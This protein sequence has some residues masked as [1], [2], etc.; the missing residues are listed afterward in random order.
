M[1]LINYM[2][3]LVQSM[4]QQLKRTCKVCKSSFAPEEN[5]DTSC[6]FHRG[7]WIG[8]ENSKHL[9]KR[10]GS[11]ENIGISFFW[12]CCDEGI[13][14]LLFSYFLKHLLAFIDN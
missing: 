6:R 1:Q 7:R 11:K 5:F 9:G 10:S 8:A 12:D 3:L 13:L 4:P 14:A 2:S